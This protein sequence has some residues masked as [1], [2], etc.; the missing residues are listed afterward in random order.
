MYYWQM[1]SYASL[2]CK[3]KTIVT[4]GEK[5]K[6]KKKPFK[7]VSYTLYLVL[8]SFEWRLAYFNYM[9]NVDSTMSNAH[10]SCKHAHV[11]MIK[12]VPN[13][14]LDPDWLFFGA[15]YNSTVL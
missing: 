5:N 11:W 9:F 15:D 2:H 1:R 13:C 14:M 10:Q 3:K 6:I 4:E 7:K 8:C 12:V